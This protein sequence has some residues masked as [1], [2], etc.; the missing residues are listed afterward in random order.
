MSITSLFYL[1]R[2]RSLDRIDYMTNNIQYYLVFSTRYRRK[3][4]K[5]NI[6]KKCVREVQLSTEADNVQI[7]NMD[8]WDDA[9]IIH[10]SAGPMLSP[11]KI[12]YLSKK[13]ITNQIK[14]CIK[15]YASITTVFNKEYLVKTNE[16]THD[17][18]MFFL[19]SQKR[20]G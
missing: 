18:I 11:H 20:R 19:E 10:V 13:C 2:Y 6:V 5:S 14:S 17:E 3:I 15:T 4:L 8:L 9:L 16:P 7:V 12:A 1:I